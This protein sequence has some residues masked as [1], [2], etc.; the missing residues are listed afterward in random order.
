[1]PLPTPARSSASPPTKRSFTSTILT[2]DLQGHERLGEGGAA[3]L[4]PGGEFALGR[5]AVAGTEADLAD[6]L[7]EL[8]GD[9]LVESPG[10]PAEAGFG[11]PSSCDQPV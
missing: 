4:E 6:V 8:A 7:V 9:L 1:M 5:Q 11:T 2:E 10:D 3:Q